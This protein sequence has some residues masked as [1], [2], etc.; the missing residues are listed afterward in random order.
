MYAID[1]AN[2]T[3]PLKLDENYD[4]PTWHEICGRAAITVAQNTD[5]GGDLGR[6]TSDV[7]PLDHDA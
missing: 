3:F 5:A 2:G 6:F 7:R 4:Y 1:G